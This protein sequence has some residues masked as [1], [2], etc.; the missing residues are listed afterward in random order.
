MMPCYG[1][2]PDIDA[3]CN[4]A[5]CCLVKK[6]APGDLLSRR[7][8]ICEPPP[9]PYVLNLRRPSYPTLGYPMR[10][11]LVIFTSH[12]NPLLFFLTIP[13]LLHLKNLSEASATAPT[14]F[15]HAFTTL[16]HPPLFAYFIIDPAP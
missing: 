11:E 15:L 16:G 7:R 2:A 14:N 8:D 10:L 6:C 12:T 13:T 1:K 4:G 3:L 9:C 5:C